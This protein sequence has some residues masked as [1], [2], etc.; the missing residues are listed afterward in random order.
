MSQTALSPPPQPLLSTLSQKKWEMERRPVGESSVC[1]QAVP[2]VWLGWRL[3]PG[4]ELLLKI[5]FTKVGETSFFSLLVICSAMELADL[6]LRKGKVIWMMM[7]WER[8]EQQGSSHH[9][10]RLV[11]HERWSFP[12]VV[13]I[14]G[15]EVGLSHFVSMRA[16]SIKREPQQQE[17]WER[18]SELEPD[19]HLQET[20]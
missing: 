14:P 8:P 10:H 16:D 4:R 5:V 1:G 11:W 20:R 19:H 9:V 2:N 6:E 18:S 12:W 15:K 3:E 7:D 17:V 13:W